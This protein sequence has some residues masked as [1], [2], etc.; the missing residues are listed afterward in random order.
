MAKVSYADPSCPEDCGQFT[1]P[2]V[3]FSDCAEGVEIEESEIC[4]IYMTTPDANNPGEPIA[5]PS[6]WTSMAAW[7]SVIAGGSVKELF[8]IGDMPESSA[9]VVTISKQRKK[10]LPSGRTINFDIDDMSQ[11]NYDFIRSL[12]C[13]QDVVIWFATI[14]G[15][16]YGGD[17]GFQVTV[18][19]ADPV[20]GR[21]EG[22]FAIGKLVLEWKQLSPPPRTLNPLAE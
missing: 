12:S 4:A 2:A 3:D 14:G 11:A 21:G 10:K 15:Y 6:D 5:K 17:K 22:T 1:L 20:L 19:T 7:E 8:G 13:G 16:M 9:N 18:T